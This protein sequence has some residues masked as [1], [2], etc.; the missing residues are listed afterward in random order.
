MQNFNY[1]SHTYRCGHADLNYSDEEYVLDY[2]KNGFDMIAFTDH[3][4]EKNPIDARINMRMRYEQKDDYLKSIDNLKKKYAGKIEI[5]SGFEVEY[6]PGEEENLKELKDETDIIILGQHFIYEEDGKTLINFG[7]RP[8]KDKEIIR[9]A[10]YLCKA[11]ELNIPDI[12]AHPDVF[13]LGEKNFGKAAEKAANIICTAAEKHNVAMEINLNYIFLK[14]YF[15]KQKLNN[16][17]LKIQTLKLNDIK[18]PRRE[19]WEIASDY[20]IKV[21]YGLDA[22]HRGQIP[23]L[24]ELTELANYILGEK[25]IGKLHFIENG[26]L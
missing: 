22:H 20:K 1:H 7:K 15:E 2:I 5:K 18:Y 9:Y 6:L 13:M 21:L 25:T 17:S 23:L 10:E 24:N 11:M 4:P 26:I 16:D 12:I 19:F 8:L 3:C 14:I